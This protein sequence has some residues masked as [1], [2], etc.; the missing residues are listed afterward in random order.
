MSVQA[1]RHSIRDGNCRRCTSL[2]LRSGVLDADSNRTIGTD[3][4]LNDIPIASLF[5]SLVGTEHTI[6][7]IAQSFPPMP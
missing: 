1:H 7:E 3:V 2:V 4:E 6:R 5:E